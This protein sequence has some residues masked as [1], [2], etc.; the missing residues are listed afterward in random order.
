MRLTLAD[1]LRRLVTPTEE[2]EAS[3]LREEARECGAQ[4]LTQCRLRSRVTLR[5]TVTAITTDLDRGRLEADLND[6]S[7]TVKLIW[8]G[9]S[10]IGCIAPG[11]T[12]RITGRLCEDQGQAAIYNPEYEVVA[13]ER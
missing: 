3:E 8:L 1:R 13:K 12:L 11:R 6:G 4:Q 10:R 9:R 2:L 5:G 7:G